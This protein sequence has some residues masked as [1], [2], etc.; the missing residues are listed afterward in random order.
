MSDI[1]VQLQSSLC[2]P[3]LLLLIFR[4]VSALTARSPSVSRVGQGEG[5]AW[6]GRCC[7]HLH[8]EM[9]AA[10]ALVPVV[11]YTQ[12]GAGGG[13]AG[14][15]AVRVQGGAIVREFAALAANSL[16]VGAGAPGHV[17]GTLLVPSEYL[18]RLLSLMFS[19]VNALVARIA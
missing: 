8:A 6:S 13:A 17:G 9:A 18:P 2:P 10:R 3:R 1:Q 7:T 15:L 11:S 4:S 5:L 14:H 19:I 12:H 16:R